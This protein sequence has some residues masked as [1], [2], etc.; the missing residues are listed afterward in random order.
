MAILVALA[1]LSLPTAWRRPS[2]ARPIAMRRFIH[3]FLLASVWGNPLFRSFT[4]DA[5]KQNTPKMRIPFARI[6]LAAAFFA[7]RW[8][9]GIALTIPVSE[10]FNYSTTNNPSDDT[11]D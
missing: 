6:C 1:Y 3:R 8:V 4:R 7:P 5:R 9:Y 11:S 2:L 10:S